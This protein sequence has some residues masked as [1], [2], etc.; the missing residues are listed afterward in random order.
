MKTQQ[1]KTETTAYDVA[2]KRIIEIVE[3]VFEICAPHG[4]KETHAAMVEILKFYFVPRDE[5]MKGVS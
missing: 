3:E 4:K 2:A 5:E 1:W